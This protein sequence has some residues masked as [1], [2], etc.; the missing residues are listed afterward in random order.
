MPQIFT[1]SSATAERAR[2]TSLSRKVQKAFRYVE[3]F[4]SASPVFDRQTDGWTD[5]RT[6]RLQPQLIVLISPFRSNRERR[7]TFRRAKRLTRLLCDLKQTVVLL[8]TPNS[9]K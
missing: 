7:L 5:R 2:I 1:K 8:D 9:V 6:Y 3:P 4:R